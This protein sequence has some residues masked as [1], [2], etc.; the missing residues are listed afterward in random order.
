MQQQGHWALEQFSFLE[1]Q[2]EFPTG[3]Q[4]HRAWIM[5][6]HNS[7]YHNDPI[8][9]EIISNK[10]LGVANGQRCRLQIP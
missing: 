6:C 7:A 4:L 5:D 9:F 10:I 8:R 1:I 2:F 3:G